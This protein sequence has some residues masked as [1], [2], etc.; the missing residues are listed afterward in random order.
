M[1][2]NTTESIGIL[3]GLLS[4]SRQ[5]IIDAYPVEHFLRGLTFAPVAEQLNSKEQIFISDNPSNILRSGNFN[6]VCYM[7][8]FNDNEAIIFFN[9]S[10]MVS[11]V[12]NGMQQNPGALQFTTI[13]LE[14]T[15]TITRS[16]KNWR[17][18]F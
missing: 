13:Q 10:E 11:Q 18:N 3:N 6:K 7:T 12:L 1:G 4:K 9:N 17:L 8:G 5:E 16:Q 15:I 14:Y 2:L